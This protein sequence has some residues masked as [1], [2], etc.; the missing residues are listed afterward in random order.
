MYCCAPSDHESLHLVSENSLE[1]L[2]CIDF[3]CINYFEMFI[4]EYVVSAG[5]SEVRDILLK[6]NNSISIV[7]IFSPM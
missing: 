3:Q 1:F 2:L 5:G 4:L 7:T 6:R